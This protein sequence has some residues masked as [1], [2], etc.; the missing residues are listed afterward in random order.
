MMWPG[1]KF[2][3]I[4]NGDGNRKT[5]IDHPYKYYILYSHHFHHI[6]TTIFFS[7]LYLYLNIIKLSQE[8]F[9]YGNSLFGS[10][11][12][13]LCSVLF[14]SIQFSSFLLSFIRCAFIQWP[15]WFGLDRFLPSYQQ[16][17]HTHTKK[18]CFARTYRAFYFTKY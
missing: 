8:H 13:A 10:L 14:C 3:R 7:S 16:Q 6:I 2:V 4:E 11:Y 18:S 1:Q 15:I 9:N 5:T 17:Q 12:A